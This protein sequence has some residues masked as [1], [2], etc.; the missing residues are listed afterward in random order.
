M[1]GGEEKL[2]FKVGHAVDRILTAA[3]LFQLE[4][5]KL[6]I[7]LSIFSKICSKGVITILGILRVPFLMK[8]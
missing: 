2:V 3:C 7:S 8:G 6:N 5:W 1:V 4:S